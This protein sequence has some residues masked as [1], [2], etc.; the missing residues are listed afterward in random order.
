MVSFE[1]YV[2]PVASH[3]QIPERLLLRDNAGQCYIWFGDG[4][5]METIP[6]PVAEWMLSRPEVAQLHSPMLWFDVSSLPLNAEVI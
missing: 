2:Q 5:D 3:R 6:V 1:S 4:R